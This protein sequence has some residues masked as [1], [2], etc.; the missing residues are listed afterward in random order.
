MFRLLNG[1]PIFLL[2]HFKH[3]STCN[4][5]IFVIIMLNSLTTSVEFCVQFSLTD[6][7]HFYTSFRIT[8]EMNPK[9]MAL[10]LQFVQS[11]VSLSSF[12]SNNGFLPIYRKKI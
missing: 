2:L 8:K 5:H 9:I 7:E 11:E 3:F 4:A 12:K 6:G 1:C 10:R